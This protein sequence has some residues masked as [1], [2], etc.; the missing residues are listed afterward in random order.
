[1]V[2]PTE[3]SIAARRRGYLLRA[4]LSVLAIVLIVVSVTAP[5]VMVTAATEVPGRSLISAS[6]FFLM[7]DATGEGFANASSVGAV[8]LALTTTYLGLALQQVGVLLGMATFWVFAVED[9][10]RWIRRFAM[11][12]GVFLTLGSATVVLGYQQLVTIGVPT[13]LGIAWL[14]TLVAGIAMMV[15]A[16]L[17]R[18]RLTSSWF[19]DRPELVQP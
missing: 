16:R 10:G 12:S 4:P 19:L 8:G 7:A 13:L 3:E 17:A 15:G 6:R 18:R 5:H 14:P 1:M 9:V 11:V 2:L